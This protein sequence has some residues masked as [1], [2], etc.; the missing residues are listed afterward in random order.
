MPLV[1]YGTIGRRIADARGRAGLTQEEL[2]RAIGLDRSALAKIETG[3]RRVTAW[4]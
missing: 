4:S 1:D 3:I 2:A